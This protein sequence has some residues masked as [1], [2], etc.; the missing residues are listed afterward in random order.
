MDIANGKIRTHDFTLEVN[1]ITNKLQS[2]TTEK[3]LEQLMFTQSR[4]PNNKAKPPY[5]KYCS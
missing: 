2:Q 3:Q 1:N 5:K 4:D